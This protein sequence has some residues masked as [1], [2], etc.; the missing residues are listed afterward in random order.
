MKQTINDRVISFVSEWL[1]CDVHKL[2]MDTRIGEDLGVDGDDAIELLEEYS[3]R[4]SVDL[5]EFPYNDYFGP[6]AG[7][8]PLHFLIVIIHS[9]FNKKRKRLN[10]LCIRDLIEGAER[11]ILR[12]NR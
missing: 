7:S 6:E 8:N 12:I 11:K 1:S 5:S 10:T 3:K 2:Y 9:L 4:F